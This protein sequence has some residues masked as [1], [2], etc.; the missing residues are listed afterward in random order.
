MPDKNKENELLD[1]FTSIVNDLELK[2][3]DALYL[4]SFVD[5]EQIVRAM[6]NGN[7]TVSRKIDLLTNVL[8]DEKST[9]AE[10]MRAM[11]MLDEMLA[12]SLSTRGIQ[13]RPVP[14]SGVTNPIGQPQALHSVEMIEKSVKMT[15]AN[16]ATMEQI[17]DDPQPLKEQT[18]AKAEENQDDSFYEDSRGQQANVFRPARGELNTI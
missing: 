10:Q 5:S 17:K 6:R 11:K 4:A 8:N 3:D 15:M 16:T 13:M 9:T 18:D 1:P 7:Y 12:N 14:V 2:Q